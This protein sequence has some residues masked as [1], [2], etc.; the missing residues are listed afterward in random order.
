MLI[1]SHYNPF[2][3]YNIY[4]KKGGGEV[5]IYDRWVLRIISRIN[6]LCCGK[7]KIKTYFSYLDFLAAIA[8]TV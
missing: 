6:I 2:I 8:V 7:N 1:I 4:R 5:K 3:V